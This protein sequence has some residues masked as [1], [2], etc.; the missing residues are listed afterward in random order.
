MSLSRSAFILIFILV[1]YSFSFS[2]LS[3]F[4]VV[5]YKVLRSTDATKRFVFVVVVVVLCFRFASQENR[6]GE[7]GGSVGK[8]RMERQAEI[9]RVLNLSTR[10]ASGIRHVH[11]LQHVGCLAILP[12]D[13][14]QLAV[15]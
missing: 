1:L 2:F 15:E 14:A 9:G 3:S 7:G 5:S 4:F 13:F 11:S 12:L 6:K 8:R 10:G